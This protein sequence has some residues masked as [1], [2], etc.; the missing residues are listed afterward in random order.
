MSRVPI[1]KTLPA[2]EPVP[3]EPMI[4]TNTF[5]VHGRGCYARETSDGSQKVKVEA[6][7][8]KPGDGAVDRR[9]AYHYKSYPAHHLKVLVWIELGVI[10]FV[11]NAGERI[12]AQF[13]ERL[14]LATV[15]GLDEDLTPEDLALCLMALR[16]QFSEDL[17]RDIRSMTDAVQYRSYIC[18]Q[19]ELRRKRVHTRCQLRWLNTAAWYPYMP[20]MLA[21]QD[22]AEELALKAEIPAWL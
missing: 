13:S 1:P 22:G 6:F 3:R 7:L 10:G 4:E 12:Y 16:P 11:A 8:H 18:E 14:Y 19:L 15:F 17:W 20:T 21:V 5:Q 9:V 2:R